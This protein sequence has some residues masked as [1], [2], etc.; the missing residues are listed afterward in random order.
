MPRR[1]ETFTLHFPRFAVK[2]GEAVV[3]AQICTNRRDFSRLAASCGRNV[4]QR[5]M[6]PSLRIVCRTNRAERH[7]Q[8][9]IAIPTRNAEAVSMQCNFRRRVSKERACVR[10]KSRDLKRE[11]PAGIIKAAPAARPFRSPRKAAGISAAKIRRS[12]RAGRRNSIHR[13]DEQRHND[14]P[15]AAKERG[16]GTRARR[17]AFRERRPVYGSCPRGCGLINDLFDPPAFYADA[18]RC[19]VVSNST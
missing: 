4:S 19:A 1:L 2:L 9:T 10:R 14:L 18:S 15:C 12:M 16:G 11:Q 3:C 8:N 5:W 13:G 7:S 6:P 17:S